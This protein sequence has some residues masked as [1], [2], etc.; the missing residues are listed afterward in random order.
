MLRAA[1]TEA[2]SELT[3]LRESMTAE[4]PMLATG[5]GRENDRLG[6]VALIEGA[7]LRRRLEAAERE[8]DHAY[9]RCSNC[10]DEAGATAGCEGCAEFI[11]EH[12][13]FRDWQERLSDLA[14]LD[15]RGTGEEGE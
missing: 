2:M 11:Q 5:G 9:F 8:R 14:L 1:L 12:P 6:L 15:R 7:E 4:R 13:I 10:G 3:E